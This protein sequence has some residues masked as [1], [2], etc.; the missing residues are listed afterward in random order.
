MRWWASLR[1]AYPRR[2]ALTVAVVTL[3]FVVLVGGGILAG[4]MVGVH[5]TSTE[6]FCSSCHANDVAAEFTTRTAPGCAQ[7]APIATCPGN[8]CR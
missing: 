6:E 7:P 5:M 4:G 3:F 1:Q 2:S 8:W